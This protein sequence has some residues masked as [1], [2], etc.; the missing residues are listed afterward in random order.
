[1]NDLNCA[2]LGEIWFHI[3]RRTVQCGNPLGDEGLELLEVCAGFPAASD[4]DALI[5]EFADA[6]MLAEMEKVFF[7]EGSNALGHSYSKLMRGPAGRSDLEDVISLLR[8]EPASKRA[9]VTLC[10]SG[11]GKV[12]CINVIEFLIREGEL[13]TIYFARG[14]DA[15]KKFHADALC[16]GK[17]ACR[18]AR[19]VEVPAGRVSGFIGS[20]HIYHEDRAAIDSFLDRA[21]EFL[22][23]AQ[24]Q[25]VC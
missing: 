22:L 20:S 6:R 10:A 1:M 17:M 19:E 25:G 5:R 13:R 12:P 3:V 8:A 2:S 9:V 14:Q 15:F 23:H 4:P 11:N 7:A 16:I 18:V 24:P 21:S